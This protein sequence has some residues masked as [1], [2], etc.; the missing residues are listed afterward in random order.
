MYLR[1]YL[2]L[3]YCCCCS[4]LQMLL[5]TFLLLLCCFNYLCHKII[6][7]FCRCFMCI[8]CHTAAC[9]MIP[10]FCTC[11]IP[12]KMQNILLVLNSSIKLP[13]NILSEFFFV[14]FYGIFL[15][16]FFIFPI[17]GLLMC[18]TLFSLFIS[19][20][21]IFVISYQFDICVDYLLQCDVYPF[22]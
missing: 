22:S 14:V 18:H 7:I 2:L 11:G 5:V 9:L 12:V 10:L 4:I 20:I 6:S 21:C 17:F 19:L 15:S 3:C 8:I 13:T 16:C 1:P